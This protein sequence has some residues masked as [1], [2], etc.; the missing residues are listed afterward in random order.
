M[1]NGSIFDPFEIAM[2]M[3]ILSISCSGFSTCRFW[4]TAASANVTRFSVCFFEVFVNMYLE[5]KKNEKERERKGR[6]RK[7]EIR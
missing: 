3:E 1:I 2:K 4:T 6:D 5:C 7:Q